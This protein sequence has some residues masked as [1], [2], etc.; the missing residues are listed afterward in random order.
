MHGDFLQA[1]SYRYGESILADTC[2][3]LFIHPHAVLLMMKLSAGI[4]LSLSYR[5]GES[6]L[7][8]TC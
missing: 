2:W 1:L 3:F 4:N 8:D 5:Y 6:I 7:A